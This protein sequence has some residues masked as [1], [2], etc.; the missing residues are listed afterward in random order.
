MS[1]THLHLHT[2]YSLL[3]GLN[4]I[5]L[6]A[7]RIKELGMD[8]V[9]IT[10]HGSMYGV[11]DFYSTMKKA[12]IKPIIG[13]ETYVAPNGIEVKDRESDRFHLILLAKNNEGYRN[14]LKI[15]SKSYIDG[16]YYKPRV[17][18]KILEQYHENLIAMSSC[19]QGEIAQKIL[20]ATK[21]EAKEA[22]YRYLDI[23][24]KGNFFLE[25]Q[26]H[27]IEDE[28]KVIK[29][30]LE[31]SKDEG[32]PLVA[33]ND[34]HYLT[35]EDAK[36]HDILLCVQ[37]L[38]NVDDPERMRFET[39]EFY[40]KSEQEMREA[41]KEMPD[42]V[43]NTQI[44]KDMCNV[45]MDFSTYH[46]PHFTEDGKEWNQ[47]ENNKL[48][49]QLTFAGLKELYKDNLEELEKRARF[50]LDVIEKMGF[51]DY[52]LIVQDFINWAKKNN[53]PVGPGRGSAAGSIVSYSLHITE[54]DPIKYQLF[55]ERF[56]NP[57]RIS[58]PDIDIDFSDRGRDKVIEYVRNKYGEDHVA[59]VAT[60]GRMEARAVIRDVGRALGFTYGEM[61]RFAKLI[62][63]GM[64]LG[65]AISTIADLKS[66]SQDPK[67]KELFEISL[68]LEGV[69]RNFSTHAAGIVIGDA[70]LTEYVPLQK[71]KDN[72]IIAQFDK[73]VV[74]HIG[75]LKMDFLGLKNLTIMQDTVESLRKTGID[76]DLRTIPEND[77][78]TFAML[79]QGDSV[80][81]FQLE[82]S[83]MRKVLK[84]V[85]PESID[86]L[87]AVVSLYRPGT[88][89]AGGIDDYINRKKGVTKVK[90]PHP[91]LEPILKGTYG[92]IV[93]Q[94][95]VMQIANTLAG[96]TLAEADTLR[97]AIGK[98]IPEI[99]QAQRGTFV[100]KAM[101]KGISKNIAEDVFNLIEYFAGYGFNKAHAVCYATIAYRTAYLK[102][103]YPREYFTAILNSY[104][105]NQD[106][107]TQ[108]LY[109]IKSKGINI[110]PPDINKSDVYF[111]VENESIRF[112]LLV[113]KNV[114]E[115]ALSEI[116]DERERQGEFTSYNDFE[117]RVKSLK[118]NKK[119][120]ESLVKAGCFDS[121]NEDRKTILQGGNH[122]GESISLFG[123]E[124]SSPTKR[125]QTTASDIM[126][127]EKEIF[128]FYI[129][130]NPL[131]SYIPLLNE[132]NIPLVSAIFD[133]ELDGNVAIAG[134]I[135]NAR[136]TK[137]KNG[138]FIFRFDFEDGISKVDTLVL[139]KFLE[140]FEKYISAEGI[141]VI[142]GSIRR[143]EDAV[144]LFAEKISS[145]L[146]EKDL[147]KKN[148][149]NAVH[150][151]IRYIE[152]SES[153]EKLRKLREEITNCRGGNPLI[154][155]MMVED[156]D[157]KITVSPKYFINNAKS[158]EEKCIAL[159]GKDCL[160][161]KSWTD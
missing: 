151:Y 10:D 158:F 70:P 7:E 67:Y 23:F 136:K 109:E 6:L 25:V 5:N 124:P 159:F 14:L 157:V 154:L 99:M 106:K 29:G 129:T 44:V 123:G 145:F 149:Y 79:K 38:S 64:S 34:A 53:I 3:D 30:M 2:E 9:A 35:K 32:I 58:M 86:D 101:Q 131:N 33:T 144:T 19:I 8:S 84:G 102:A 54:I 48:L 152:Q 126:S 140:N 27:G 63:M 104:I 148:E 143:E 42:A 47:E 96:Y 43:D 121:L 76:I 93:Y 40:V 94:E 77:E 115:K 72:S 16:F 74:E 73:D 95:Q 36:A 65:D 111:K 45:E 11:V 117:N 17:D 82:S 92:I 39:Q 98:K 37:T 22:L 26:N 1:F 141:A 81:V 80:G 50:E 97:K 147:K 156:V 78:A 155:H 66:S 112:G 28:F 24:G 122:S 119:V 18:Y 55:F 20:K 160:K 49:E 146:T 75:L 15:V 57:E 13:V 52:F 4:K 51:T 139:P 83:G 125:Y 31:L 134:V 89:K 88:I 21:K 128:G 71:D 137:T 103:H 130:N 142:E 132:K 153:I 127:Y 108:I 105:D 59:Q 114:G 46:L 120:S 116:I 118:V 12:N 69:V 90:Y 138:N 133:E 60:F 61:D 107:L 161:I 150:L 85:Q 135:S 113:I 56:L 87:T 41:F 62:P 68:K 110:L 91:S 100:E